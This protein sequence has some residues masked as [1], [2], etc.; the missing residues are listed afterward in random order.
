MSVTVNLPRNSK[1]LIVGRNFR[2][3]LHLFITTATKKEKV[4]VWLILTNFL[5]FVT[6]LGFFFVAFFYFHILVIQ[7]TP[8]HTQTHTHLNDWKIQ[9]LKND[10]RKR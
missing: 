1:L 7:Q 3:S 10:F 4:V 2:F 6:F 9:K 8:P 5:V